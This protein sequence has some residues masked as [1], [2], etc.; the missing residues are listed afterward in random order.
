MFISTQS[1]L[2][3]HEN[4]KSGLASESNCPPCRPRTFHQCSIGKGVWWTFRGRLNF[5]VVSFFVFQIKAFRSSI[6]VLSELMEITVIGDG[7]K[8]MSNDMGINKTS[9]GNSRKITGNQCLG[10]EC[11]LKCPKLA[12]ENDG[13][14][15]GLEFTTTLVTSH[16]C[17]EHG[18]TA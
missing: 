18:R 7:R 3:P 4:D 13:T 1:L 9:N 15:R 5:L 14:G 12:L 2:R 11:L 16:Q 10:R 6:Q 17:I 8:F